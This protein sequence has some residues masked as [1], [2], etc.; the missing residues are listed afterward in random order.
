MNRREFLIGLGVVGTGICFPAVALPSPS[1]K[2]IDIGGAGCNLAFALRESK[3]LN[4][5]GAELSYVGIDLGPH[6]FEFV[7]AANDAN[8][9]L[10]P[11]NTLMLAPV[12]AGGRVNAARAAC[13]S[14]RAILA[15]M[16]AGSEIVVLLAGLGGGTGSGITP[17]MA[18][19]ARAAG[20]VTIATV[21]TPFDF[22]GVRNRRSDA[23]VAHLQRD[24]DLVM[25]FPNE[26]WLNRFSGD[27][28]L[29]DIFDALDRHI[30]ASVQAVAY[31]LIPHHL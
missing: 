17:Y 5:A 4:R 20:A 2:I 10:A 29:L 21:V 6:S 11:I 31:S 13:L 24:T 19:A 15:D 28:P 3:I 30:A 14:H 25:A 27:T 18:R 26:E 12:R 16:L 1:C 23:V 9:S 7:E 8:P 22:E